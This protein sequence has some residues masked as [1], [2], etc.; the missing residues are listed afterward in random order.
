MD[1]ILDL[2]EFL[3]YDQIN[4]NGVPYLKENLKK[5]RESLGMTQSEFGKSVGIAKT[6]Y[7]NYETGVREPKSDFWI[8]VAEKYGVTID[9][10]MGY[11]QNPHLTIEEDDKKGP[12]SERE[13]EDNV[14]TSIE[15]ELM[16]YVDRLTLEQK[17]FLL[18]QMKLMNEEDQ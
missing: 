12:A 3:C 11:S 5:L 2:F 6:T 16:N 15:K 4:G 18:A 10:L 17:K 14:L 1:F 8:A 9:Y 7:N 13:A